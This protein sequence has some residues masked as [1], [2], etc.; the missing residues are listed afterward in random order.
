MT[1]PMVLPRRIYDT[2]IVEPEGIQHAQAVVKVRN[3]A[4]SGSFGSA[5]SAALMVDERA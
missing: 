1:W 4:P 5:E 3:R 2:A